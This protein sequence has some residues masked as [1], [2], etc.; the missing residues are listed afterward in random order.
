MKLNTIYYVDSSD[1]EIK[2]TLGD[3]NELQLEPTRMIWWDIGLYLIGV[4]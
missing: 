4:F 2:Y 1:F 3:Y